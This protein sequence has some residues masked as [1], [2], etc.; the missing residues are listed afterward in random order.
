MVIPVVDVVLDAV[1]AVVAIRSLHLLNAASLVVFDVSITEAVDLEADLL[2]PLS[3]VRRVKCCLATRCR[4]DDVDFATPTVVDDNER[5]SANFW[6]FCGSLYCFVVFV[7]VVVSFDDF[8]FIY[9]YSSL[10]R[11]GK[12]GTA[13]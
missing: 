6:L 1:V 5:F 8:F 3:F 11:A 4:N 12:E 2:P 7:T 13:S 9:S 10:G